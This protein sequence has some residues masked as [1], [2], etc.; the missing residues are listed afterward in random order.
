MTDA[1]RFLTRTTFG[2]SELLKAHLVRTPTDDV[3]CDP[4]RG[5]VERKRQAILLADAGALLR[6]AD[7]AR[8][9]T[10][11][12]HHARHGRY[13]GEAM[14][15]K[16]ARSPG[17]L[18]CSMHAVRRS[19]RN[20]I[21]RA[22]R[23]RLAFLLEHC[24]R[25]SNRGCRGDRRVAPR[26]VG[27][28]L[29]TLM[30]ALVACSATSKPAG[31]GTAASPTAVALRPTPTPTP[32]IGVSVTVA[33]CCTATLPTQWTSPQP[34][35][36]GEM[37]STDP[38]GRLSVTWQVIGAARGCPEE[39]PAL[40]DSLTSPTN[41]SGVTIRAV[42]PLMV[43][44]HRVALYVTA[45]SDASEHNVEF[46]NADAA[47]GARCYNLGGALNG[48]ASAATVS[49]LIQILASSHGLT[50]PTAPPASSSSVGSQPH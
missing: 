12:H 9:T 39:P 22:K 31:S 20:A 47:I 25:T 32:L 8:A 46:L 10:A 29:P 48:V 26:A 34:V 43:G 37:G 28:L 2:V 49:T 11:T 7:L 35:E 3:E 13:R 27:V 15:V 5:H 6:S 19:S 40:L 21:V 45:P 38:T 14:D 17:L 16:Q 4:E 36:N 30:L 42:L 18:G 23:W 33:G 50:L 1:L 24:G 41:P 44:G